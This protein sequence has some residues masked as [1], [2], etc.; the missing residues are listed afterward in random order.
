ML[1]TTRW[2][3]E[4]LKAGRITVQMEISHRDIL[5]NILD[6]LFPKYRGC[7]TGEGGYYYCTNRQWNGTKTT[8]LPTIKLSEL[9][10]YGGDIK[11]FPEEVVEKMLERQVEQGN[12]RNIAQFEYLRNSNK[13]NKGFEWADSV[14]GQVF[15]DNV[16]MKRRF[17]VFFEKYPKQTTMSDKKIIG[18][19]API[20]MFTNMVGNTVEKGELFIYAN[21][22]KSFYRAEKEKMTTEWVTWIPKEI[23]ETWEPVYEEQDRWFAMTADFNVKVKGNRAFYGTEDITDAVLKLVDKFSKGTFYIDKYCCA[24][25]TQ[26]I[27]FTQLGCR[28]QNTQLSDWIKVYDAINKKD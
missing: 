7:F 20:R 6:E 9:E 1:K 12:K 22:N 18:Y 5:R 11:D 23:G 21:D 13:R 8:K 26:S 24:V 3:K 15:W 2:L 14:E 4:E 16:I 28:A 19:K 27:T 25:E 17:S 10:D